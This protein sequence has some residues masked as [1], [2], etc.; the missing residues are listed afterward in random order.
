MREIW[1]RLDAIVAGLKQR[2]ALEQLRFVREYGSES[3]EVNVRSPLAVVG[4]VQASRERGYIGR[5][6]TASLHGETY[7]AEAEIRL[8][9][10]ADANGN[11]LAEIVSEVL[12]GLNA[13][14]EEHII[15]SASASSIEFD[16]DL[17]AVFR[18]VTFHMAF[19]VCEKEWEDGLL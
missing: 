8:Y 2:A 6:V 9:A 15:T 4:V 18:R 7:S 3:A 1:Q 16:P 12:A 14:D 11:G 5:H 10:P 13:A 19:C 17:N